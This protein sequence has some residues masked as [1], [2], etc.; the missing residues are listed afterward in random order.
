M[1]PA[2]TWRH[3]AIGPGPWPLADLTIYG[4]AQGLGGG[5]IDANPDEAQ[6]IWAANG[7]DALRLAPGLVDVPARSPPPTGCTSRPLHRSLRQPNETHI[8]AIAGG[9]PGQVYVGYYGYETL[10]NP[11]LD[12]DAQKELGNGD[13]VT[14][15]RRRQDRPSRAA[16]PLRRRA[17]QRLL[18][19]SLAAPHHLRALGVAAGHSF[20]GF[21]HGVT[22]VLSDD[23]GDHIHPEVWYH[24]AD[25]HRRP[26]SS[27][28]STASPSTPT[29]NLW[30]AGRYAVGLQP[31]N[32]KPHGTRSGAT[33]G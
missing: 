32:P 33:S 17:R 4:S 24:A 22:H 23:F 3:G 7:D 16:V 20:W 14:L 5:I 9:T 1:T 8:T 6:N 10:G 12:T 27:A 19:E 28:S 31:W 2:A 15:E 29:G 25:G 21:N 13:D 30:M 11:F 18:G 26:R